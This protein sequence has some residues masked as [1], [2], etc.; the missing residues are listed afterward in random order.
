MENQKYKEEKIL[1]PKEVDRALRRSTTDSS[2]WDHPWI[3]SASAFQAL[4]AR[5]STFLTP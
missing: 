3:T 5:A 4:A 2:H 1:L